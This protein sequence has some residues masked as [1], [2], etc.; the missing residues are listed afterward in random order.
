MPRH[1]SS[2]TVANNDQIV[3]SICCHP[4]QKSRKTQASKAY[5]KTKIL[6]L[7]TRDKK[8]GCIWLS[9]EN[10]IGSYMDVSITVILVNAI[11]LIV[12]GILREDPFSTTIPALPAVAQN[13]LTNVTAPPVNPPQAIVAPAVVQ[14]TQD[15]AFSPQVAAYNQP[16]TKLMEPKKLQTA[17]PP[18]AAHTATRKIAAMI[19]TCTAEQA[20]AVQ[21]RIA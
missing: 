12:I 7:L 3:S 9:G 6:V 2:C 11:I 1:F 10:S 5:G 20:N 8:F 17:L 14:I 18:L 4:Q 19:A 16:D 13:A 15:N 21:Q